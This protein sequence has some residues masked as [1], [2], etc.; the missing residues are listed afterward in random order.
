MCPQFKLSHFI[1]VIQLIGS[2]PFKKHWKCEKK[3]T[4]ANKHKNSIWWQNHYQFKTATGWKV[5]SYRWLSSV[6]IYS[7]VRDFQIKSSGFICNG[8]STESPSTQ[9]NHYRTTAVCAS[10]SALVTWRSMSSSSQR[11]SCCFS[12]TMSNCTDSHGCVGSAPL[13]SSPC[14]QGRFSDK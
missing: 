2:N 1:C 8:W 14:P 9:G 11:S 7:K 6:F 13:P 4:A 3:T 5:T 10:A 12:S